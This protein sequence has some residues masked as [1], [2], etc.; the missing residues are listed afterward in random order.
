M[1]IKFGMFWFFMA[2][3][4]SSFCAQQ[5]DAMGATH[6]VAKAE[7]VL[8]HRIGPGNQEMLVYSK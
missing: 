6:H 3:G 7:T 8:G 1:K 2:V 4:V 5:I